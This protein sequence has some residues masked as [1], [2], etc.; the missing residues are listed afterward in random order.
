M[1]VGP[2]GDEAVYLAGHSLGAMPRAG[3]AQVLAELD[4][5]G[6]LGVEGH[7]R[8]V[9]PWFTYSDRLVAPLAR[10]VG[11]QEPEVVAMNTLTVNLHVLFASFYRPTR[12]RFKVLMRDVKPVPLATLLDHIDH[13][14]RVA[15]VD[16][17][18]LGSDFDGISSLPVGLKDAADLPRITEGLVQRGYSDDDIM[19]ILGGNLARV[20]REALDR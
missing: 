8:A 16:H 17:V 19:K 11:A 18:G 9:N 7:F 20:F 12:A 5:W 1:P 13:V 15:G 10:L 2:D 4:D 6:R 14:A 3:R